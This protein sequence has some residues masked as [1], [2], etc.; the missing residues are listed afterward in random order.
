M[1]CAGP[2]IAVAIATFAQPAIQTG[3]AVRQKIPD[4]RA[5]DQNGK[6]QTLASISGPEG[7]ML[8]FYRSADW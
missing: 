8:V 7:A 5:Q 6:M 3:P 4:F 2:L 1:K